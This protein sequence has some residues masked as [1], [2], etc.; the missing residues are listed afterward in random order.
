QQFRRSLRHRPERV[1]EHGL[2]E[3]TRGPDHWGPGAHQFLHAL[4]VHALALLLAEE[5]LSA[6]RAAAEG[7]LARPPWFDQP[8]RAPGHLA[9]RIVR[10]AIASQVTRIVVGDIAHW[11]SRRKPLA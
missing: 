3:R 2:A 8:A 5:H 10:A 6:A 4:H 11:R 9:R 7:A 1:A